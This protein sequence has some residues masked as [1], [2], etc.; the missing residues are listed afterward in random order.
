MK[1]HKLTNLSKEIGVVHNEES[2]NEILA[3]RT[4]SPSLFEEVLKIIGERM[5]AARQKKSKEIDRRGR[6]KGVE[7]PKCCR[8]EL[9]EAN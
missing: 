1:T 6:D 7:K 2:W 9:I 4:H 5:V 8:S 3:L